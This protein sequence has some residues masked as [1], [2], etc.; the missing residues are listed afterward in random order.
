MYIYKLASFGL[1]KIHNIVSYAL[2][3][4][5]YVIRVLQLLI[6]FHADCI[7]VYKLQF[8][9]GVQFLKKMIICLTLKLFTH[10]N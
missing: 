2:V 5:T 3:H 7:T 8:V 6:T 9:Y 1:V 10:E 4:N